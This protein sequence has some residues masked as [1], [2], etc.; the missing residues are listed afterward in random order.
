MRVQILLN[1]S[2]SGISPARSGE[3]EIDLFYKSKCA[4]SQKKCS[5]VR[6][7]PLRRLL[8][9][10]ECLWSQFVPKFC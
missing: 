5:K 10:V 7:K 3:G 2:F 8:H 6:K 1:S 9:N 4:S